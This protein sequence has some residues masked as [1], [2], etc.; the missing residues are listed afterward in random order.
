MA[1]YG[2]F[3]YST[4]DSTTETTYGVSYGTENTILYCLGVDWNG[5]GSYDQFNEASRVLAWSVDRGRD[6][7]I[8]PSGNGFTPYNIGRLIVTL[9]NH[10]GRYDS[11]NTSSALYGNLMPGKKMQFRCRVCEYAN[12]FDIEASTDSCTVIGDSSVDYNT[13]RSTHTGVSN[14]IG[15][16]QYL[17]RVY[18]FK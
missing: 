1:R 13:A 2:T 3:T 8:N 4:T 5:D 16:G 6:S 9:D 14:N 18:Q 17:I 7:I 11:W 10:D 15:V 12:T